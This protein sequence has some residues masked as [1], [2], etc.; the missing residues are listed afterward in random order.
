M[1]FSGYGYSEYIRK[2][3]EVVG[4]DINALEWKDHENWTPYLSAGR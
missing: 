4:N 2:A 3:I 1:H